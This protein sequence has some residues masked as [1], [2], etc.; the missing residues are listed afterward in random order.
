MCLP[1]T[2]NVKGRNY[3]LLFYPLITASLPASLPVLPALG[4]VFRKDQNIVAASRKLTRQGCGG[5][6]SCFCLL[7]M[8]NFSQ[9]IAIGLAILSV[10]HQ[11][12]HRVLFVISC[13][14]YY[15]LALNGKGGPK[16]EERRFQ[17]QLTLPLILGSVGESLSCSKQL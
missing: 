5:F 12:L 10:D 15:F 3:P 1:L 6:M 11:C 14:P 16:K 7:E 13:F 9:S 2:L 8:P 17:C 4:W